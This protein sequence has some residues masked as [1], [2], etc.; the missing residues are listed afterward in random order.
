MKLTVG[1]REVLR[2]MGMSKTDMEEVEELARS[3]ITEEDNNM[4]ELLAD[5]SDEELAILTE[6]SDEDIVKSCT[7]LKLLKKGQLNSATRGKREAIPGLHISATINHRLALG[8]GW[9]RRGGL[10]SR[11]NSR[12]KY[13][14]EHFSREKYSQEHYSRK[15]YSQDHYSR[16]QYLQDKGER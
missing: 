12:E 1:E 4:E 3:V 7:E 11:E 2:T 14:Q 13:L 6:G 8:L 5:L 9:Q 16:E 10:G 15:K